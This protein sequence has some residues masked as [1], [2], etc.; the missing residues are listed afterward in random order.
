[1]CFSHAETRRRG[2]A[3]TFALTRD[4]ELT[5][6]VPARMTSRLLVVIPRQAV[7]VSFRVGGSPA[8]VS[9]SICDKPKAGT[10]RR[11]TAKV[12]WLTLPLQAIVLALDLQAVRR[13][14]VSRGEAV[15]QMRREFV[16]A[17]KR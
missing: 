2:D 14:V 15:S 11:G 9:R 6:T 3:E 10:T 1:M 17:R 16:V 13:R 7:F 12:V 8:F 5:R 4:H